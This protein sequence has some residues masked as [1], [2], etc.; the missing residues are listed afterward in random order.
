MK[1]SPSEAYSREPT[2]LNSHLLWNP[3]FYYSVRKSLLSVRILSQFNPFQTF[4]NL[5]SLTLILVIWQAF[6]AILPFSHPNQK[7]KR[8]SHRPH[9][10]YIPC[11]LYANFDLIIRKVLYL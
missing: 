4:Q 6:R 8:F 2:R 9:A 7:L 10:F 11:P 5:I 3:K 1:Q